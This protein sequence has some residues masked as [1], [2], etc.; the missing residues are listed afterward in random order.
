MEVKHV[1]AELPLSVY[2][3]LVRTAKRQ[4]KPLKAVAEEAI[5]AYVRA[6]ENWE[7]DPLLKLIGTGDLPEG[8]WSERKDWRFGGKRP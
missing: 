1:Q 7:D 5:S 6:Q 4:G 3:A 2:D 8:N